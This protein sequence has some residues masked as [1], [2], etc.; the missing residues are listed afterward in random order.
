MPP[1]GRHPHLPEVEETF[2]QALE[3]K[4]LS[5]RDFVQ[6]VGAVAGM[7]GLDAAFVPRIAEA[8]QAKRKLP[9]VWLEFQDCAGNTESF[10]RAAKPSIDEIILDAISVNYPETIMA[11]AGHLAEEVLEKTVRESKGQYLG[12]GGGCIPTAAGGGDS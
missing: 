3:R 9:L 6:F 7:L 11:A 4:G 1:T 10:L 5:R 12:G 8:L 2:Y